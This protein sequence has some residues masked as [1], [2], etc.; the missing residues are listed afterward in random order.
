MA[1][2]KERIM[3]V[4]RIQT[5]D[6]TILISKHTHDFVS[7]EDKNGEVYFVDG[8]MDYQRTTLNKEPAKDL[9]LYWDDPYEE[10]RKLVFRGTFDENGERVWKPIC[11]LSNKHLA[12]IV[13]YNK[14]YGHNGTLH[15]KLIKREIKYRKENGILIEDNW[16][17]E[18]ED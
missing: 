11:E 12:N 16:K 6:G 10:I 13:K 17:E 2:K 15:D 4:N 9:R 8:G 7:H 5:P 14:F 3:V 1:K 18:D